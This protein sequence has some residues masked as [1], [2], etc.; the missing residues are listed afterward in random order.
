MNWVSQP[1]LTL[2]GRWRTWARRILQ[3]LH[4]QLRIPSLTG[5]LLVA[6]SAGLD[7]TVLLHLMACVAPSLGA[8]IHAGHVHHGLRP[9][10]E[11]EAQFAQS[12]CHSF[13][14]PCHV[15]RIQLSGSMASPGI[16]NTARQARYRWLEATRQKLGCDW[17]LTAHHRDD[18]AEDILLRL[19]RGT[20]WPA[21]GG[22]PSRDDQ[23]HLL[24]P[25]LAIPKK[26]LRAYAQDHDLSW[27]E[28]PSNAMPL[29]RR[30]RLRLQVLPLLRQENPQVDLAF[31][32][33]HGM[34]ALDREYWDECTRPWR[35]TR[36]F[37]NAQLSGLHPAM[38]LRLFKTA[39]ESLGPGQAVAAA[40]MQVHTL[41]MEGRFPRCIQFP[42]D[43]YALIRRDGIAFGRMY[44]KWPQF[45]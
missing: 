2:R 5:R 9:E 16:E 11:E 12:F 4:F 27:R 39:V 13:G 28:D 19:I 22:M 25:L 45:P 10:S 40:L 35:L 43:K 14:I 33:L 24:R 8:E 3:D 41:W 26:E 6:Y 23:R 20:G 36:F 21:L 1:N 34:A 15:G 18:L 42:G 29:T 37:P 30:N 32:H 17:I 38:R 31:A 44:R 7:S